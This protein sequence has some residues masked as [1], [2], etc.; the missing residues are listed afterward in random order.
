MTKKENLL[1][2]AMEECNELS[3]AISKALRFGMDNYCEET[4]QT[5]DNNYRILEEYIQLT[6]V[7]NMLLN[8]GTLQPV[9]DTVYTVIKINKEK[10]VAK[11]QEYS[12]S[13]GLVVGD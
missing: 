3:M 8:E 7:M 9:S 12:K 10:N 13:I 5:E 2:T 4:G 6:T 11:Y 1:V